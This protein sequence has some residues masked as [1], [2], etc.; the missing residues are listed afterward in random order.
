MSEVAAAWEQDAPIG[1][2]VVIPTLNEARNIV[3]VLAALPLVVDE[4]ILVDGHSVD[5]TVEAALGVRHDLVVVRQSRRGKG[6]AL[7][8]GIAAARGEYIVLMDADGSMDPAEIH[9]FVAALDAG[10][11]YVKGSR[12]RPGGGSTD[13]TPLRRTGNAALNGLTNL[14][15]GTRFTDLCY[16]Y[17]AFRRSHDGVFRLADPHEPSPAPLWGDGFEIETLINIRAATAGL[18]IHEIA[19]FEHP[20]RHGE[21]NL[22]TFRDGIRVLRTI[23]RERLRPGG[24]EE[25]GERLGAG[26]PRPATPEME[27]ARIMPSSSGSH[28]HELAHD[29]SAPRLA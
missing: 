7:A 1:I 28:V 25:T 22:N 23:L 13:I 5:G 12:F 24:Q 6:N 26:G 14:L 4:V 2:S 17:N 9:A 29:S 8:A 27:L 20:R 10:A 11:D 18:V 15:F 3:H 19:S 21:S 16:G